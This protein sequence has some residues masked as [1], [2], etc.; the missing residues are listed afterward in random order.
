MS[1]E[2]TWVQLRKQIA[3]EAMETFRLDLSNQILVGPFNDSGFV[4]PEDER[5]EGF[6]IFFGEWLIGWWP[7]RNEAS[8]AATRIC[9]AIRSTKLYQKR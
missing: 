5:G 4:L 3:Y 8:E 6:A 7:T 1:V 2:E 9:S